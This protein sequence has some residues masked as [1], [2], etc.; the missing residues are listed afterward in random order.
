MRVA[1]MKGDIWQLLQD[2]PIMTTWSLKGSLQSSLSSIIS[3]RKL[4]LHQ[5][6]Q[7]KPPAL[8]DGFCPALPEQADENKLPYPAIRNQSNESNESYT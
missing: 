4:N 8:W 3:P 2:S 5:L 1:K 6:A 7:D